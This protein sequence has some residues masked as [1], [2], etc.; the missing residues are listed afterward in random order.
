MIDFD[1]MFYYSM[2]YDF[3]LDTTLFLNH[4]ML[5]MFLSNFAL[6]TV[7]VVFGI[8]YSTLEVCDVFIV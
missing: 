3:T 8:F 4:S 1:V 6:S 7:T 5:A 2:M